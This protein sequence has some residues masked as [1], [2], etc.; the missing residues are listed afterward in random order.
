MIIPVPQAKN[1]SNYILSDL[2][3]ICLKYR[4][5]INVLY[6]S[7]YTKMFTYIAK[8]YDMACVCVYRYHLA[9][10]SHS[11]VQSKGAELA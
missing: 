5:Y 9:I 10:S 3:A 1:I 6:Y 11:T 8:G 4:C 2:T 7:I